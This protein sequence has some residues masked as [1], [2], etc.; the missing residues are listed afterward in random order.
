MRP[1]EA[2]LRDGR[3]GCSCPR[4][5]QRERKHGNSRLMAQQRAC[6]TEHEQQQNYR[7]AA[8]GEPDAGEYG[9]QDKHCDQ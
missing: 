7:I 9:K 4:C 5:Q 2:A 1:R 6:R 3:T 8:L